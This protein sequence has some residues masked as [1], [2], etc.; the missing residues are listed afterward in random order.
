MCFA[1]EQLHFFFYHLW[2]C[3]GNMQHAKYKSVLIKTNLHK[4]QWLSLSFVVMWTLGSSGNIVKHPHKRES[5]FKL[6]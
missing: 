4:R 6:S 2:Y 5:Q 1:Y 3:I